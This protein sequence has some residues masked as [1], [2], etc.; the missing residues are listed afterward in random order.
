M[1]EEPTAKAV[2]WIASFPKSGNTWVQTVVREAGKRFGFPATDLDVYRLMADGRQPTVVRGIRPR[3]SKL[4]TTVLKTHRAFAD[5][6]QLHPQLRLQ[7]AGFVYVMRNPLDMLLSYINFTRMQYDNDRLRDSAEFQKMLFTDLLGMDRVYTVEQWREMRLEDLPRASLDHALRKFGELD[8]L[9]PTMQNTI[10]GTWLEHA[11]SWHAAAQT[12]PGV[13]LRYEDLLESPQH[14]LAMQKIFT[15]KEA[16][17]LDAAREVDERL[18]ARQSKTIFFNKMT[19][20]YFREFFSPDVVAAF[21]A[22]FE[23]RLRALGYGNLYDAA[24]APAPA[25]AAATA[26]A[27][28]GTSPGPA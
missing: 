5:D 9:L 23:P 17:I 18:R 28:A 7:T 24:P 13:V 1:S 25:N 22:R 8:T 15:F 10:G 2:I 21:L 19:S 20:Y 26:L 16:Q 12:L 4:P 6:K 27:A 3:I 14:F 11:E